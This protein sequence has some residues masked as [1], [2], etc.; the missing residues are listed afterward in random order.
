[1]LG[2][3]T[4]RLRARRAYTRFQRWGASQETTHPFHGGHRRHD[5]KNKLQ[6]LQRFLMARKG[7]LNANQTE[8]ERLAANLQLLTCRITNRNT[9]VYNSTFVL[10]FQE[11]V[12]E[13]RW[14]GIKLGLPL[15]G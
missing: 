11:V 7:G 4:V 1:M 14:K 13:S 15:E 8:T 6:E 3:S 10:F 5:Q 12:G 2:S 9:R